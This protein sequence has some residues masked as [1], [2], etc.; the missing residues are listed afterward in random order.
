MTIK[1]PTPEQLAEKNVP[2]EE[3][4]KFSSPAY[5]MVYELLEY[6]EEHGIPR[7]ATLDYYECGSHKLSLSW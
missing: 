1:R 3:D 6:M 7:E 4:D 2:L 5:P